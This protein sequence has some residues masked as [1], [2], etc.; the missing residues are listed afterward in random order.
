MNGLFLLAAGLI[1]AGFLLAL[2]ATRFFTAD[3]PS[4]L[5]DLTVDAVLY[6]IPVL[7]LLGMAAL[8]VLQQWNLLVLGTYL[9]IPIVLGPILFLAYSRRKCGNGHVNGLTFR[10]LLIVYLINFSMSLILLYTFETRTFLYYALIAIIATLI[11]LEI[12]LFDKRQVSVPVILAQ[13][14]MLVLNIIWSINLKYYF[15]VG[16]TD[17]LLHSWYVE[18]I[19]KYGFVSSVF[20]DYQTFPLWHILNAAAYRITG[21]DFPVHDIMFINIGII[22]VV[23]AMGVFLVAL[24]VTGNQRTAMLSSLFVAVYPYFI[25]IGSEALARSVVSCLGVI[26]LLLLLDSK[27]KSRFWLSVLVTAG[28]IVFHPVAILFILVILATMYLAQ[29]IFVRDPEFSLIPGKYF[30]VAIPMLALYWLLFGN[31]IVQALLYS[32]RNLGAS[33]QVMASVIASPASELFNYLQFV[34]FLLFIIVGTVAILRSKGL[35]HNAKIIALT[36]LVLVPLTFPGP[37][38]LINKFFMDVEM[39]RF[40]ENG[41][42]FM[43]L[44]AAIGFSALFLRSGRAMKAVL[45]LLF[46]TMVLLSVSNDFVATDN[47]LVKRP[48]FTH[49]ISSG[50]AAIIEHLTTMTTGYILSD[51]VPH[52]YLYGSPERVKTH[53][54]EVDSR[55]L[56]FLRNSGED[57]LVIRSGELEGRPLYVSAVDDGNFIHTPGWRNTVYYTGDSPLWNDLGRY[58]RV[59]D[60]NSIQGYN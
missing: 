39:E 57:L 24:K 8:L 19:V 47:P 32:V 44:T 52:R 15:Y 21:V 58:S 16:R 7:G 38:L 54:L 46:V 5:Y 9:I 37:A 22:Y 2:Y 13:I 31:R 49:Y 36:A 29:K 14:S 56:T 25:L 3:R 10:F 18:N 33:T 34:P 6:A 43:G 30:A 11:M 59:Y 27:V 17:V 55:N 50:D 45:T 1:V 60:S 28:I 48:F 51:Y 35:G 26:L 4:F 41:F 23:I 53:I 40:F 20:E 12:L 42:V